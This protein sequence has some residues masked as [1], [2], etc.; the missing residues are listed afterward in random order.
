M[1]AAE[2]TFTPLPL[3]GAFAIAA[4]R[5]EDERGSFSRTWCARELAAQ[6]LNAVMAQASVSENPRRGTLRGLHYQAPPHDEAKLVSCLR[7]TIWD[8][9]VDLRPKSSTFRDWYAEELSGE[10]SRALYMPEGFAHGF[11]TVS[12]DVLVLY[13][14]SEFYTPSHAR[15]VRW[16]DPA[17]AIDWPFAPLVINE[18]DASYPDFE[19]RDGGAEGD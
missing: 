4:A 15:G 12:D 16:N 17:F 8:V 1:G 19:I 6:G 2:L 7:G 9:M 18:R 5:H 11:L 10:R 14:V 13:E 3:A